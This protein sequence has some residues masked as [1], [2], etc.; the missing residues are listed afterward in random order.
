MYTD[1]YLKDEAR[2]EL[3]EGARIVYEAVSSTLGPRGRNV[4]IEKAYGRPRITKDGVS[5]AKAIT[6]KGVQNNGAQILIE[7]ASRSNEDSGDGT[8]TATIL[9]YS[10][11]QE[12]MKYINEG[13][14]SPSELKKE[15][16]L[17]LDVLLA[18]VDKRAVPVTTSQEI[19]HI[20]TVSA[21][22]DVEIGSMLAQAFELV[23]A[24]GAITIEPSQKLGMELEIV[25]GAQYDRG[26]VS[27]YFINNQER[28]TVEFTNA[29]VVLVDGSL[30]H[31]TPQIKPFFDG[32][33]RASEGRPILIIADDVSGDVLRLLIANKIQQG[34]RIAAI[35][36]PG[37]GDRRKEMMEDLAVM[38]GG[39]VLGSGAGRPLDKVSKECFGS[40]ASVVVRRDSTTIVDGG[41]DK[42]RLQ[43]RIEA[44]KLLMSETPSQYDRE[45]C[46]ERMSKLAGKVAVIKVGGSSELEVGEKKDRVEDALNATR[47]AAKSGI[48]PGG[49]KAFLILADIVPEIEVSTVV[50]QLLVDVLEQ[51]F[52][53]LL[54][55]AWYSDKEHDKLLLTMYESHAMMTYDIREEKL[56]DAQ[57]AGIIDPAAVIKNS[58]RNAISVAGMMLTTDAIIANEVKLDTTKPLTY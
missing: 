45:K 18:E 15:L 24:G 20:G 43:Q 12:G 30:N 5:V 28:S 16:D 34:L 37:F 26:Y 9:A 47:A 29:M 50:K 44:V 2:K 4:V 25:E 39:I 17:C 51:P 55:N 10:L 32:V 27:P 3:L 36:S 14:I 22:G 52:S 49:G 54:T 58:L 48:V 40:A 41:G 8:T 7:A 33:L 42:Q 46:E 38:T 11:M 19:E 21:N 31:F 56:V 23:G 53:K 57:Q 35:K 1:V 13:K 6:L